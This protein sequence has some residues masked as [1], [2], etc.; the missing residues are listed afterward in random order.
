MTR[1]CRSEGFYNI[2]AS[3]SDTQLE[4]FLGQVVTF[5][6]KRLRYMLTFLM[7]VHRG[8][9]Q[10]V[11]VADCYFIVNVLDLPFASPIAIYR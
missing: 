10:S 5:P 6:V 9:T 8:P 4:T 2:M 7:F 3:A 11:C 1:L